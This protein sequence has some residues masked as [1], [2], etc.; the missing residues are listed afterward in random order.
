VNDWL[1]RRSRRPD[2]SHRIYCFPFAGGSPGAYLQWEQRL[3]ELEVW[4]VLPPGRGRRFE[5][6]PFT[7][8]PEYVAALLRDIAFTPPY[9]L[10][11]HSLGG[12]L[13][14]E[15]ARAL[16]AAG[17]PGPQAVIVSAH[18]PPHRPPED[19]PITGLSED[20]FRAEITRRYPPLP[21][22]LAEDPELV[23]LSY[24]MLRSD[25]ELVESY[26]YQPGRPLSCPLAVVSGLEDYWS[27]QD[28]LGWRRQTSSRFQVTMVP[29]DHHYLLERPDE[30]LE[31]IADLTC[32]VLL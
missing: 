27:E 11:G 8:V 24:R 19:P 2:A 21:A 6:T 31:I 3:P 25:L 23:A 18:R 32:G 30:V 1:V 13:A 5:E 17:R 9:L 15:T 29:G 16:E 20:E 10:F 12:L 26:R 7:R 22:E 28:L 14:F 4:G